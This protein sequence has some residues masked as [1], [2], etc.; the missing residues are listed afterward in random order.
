MLLSSDLYWDFRSVLPHLT[1]QA[2][3]LCTENICNTRLVEHLCILVRCCPSFFSG[4]LRIWQFD[5]TTLGKVS[6]AT[7]ASLW[8]M[9]DPSFTCTQSYCYELRRFRLLYLLYIRRW[10]VSTLTVAHLDLL[11]SIVVTSLPRG[12]VPVIG[13]RKLLRWMTDSSTLQGLWTMIDNYHAG[14]AFCLLWILRTCDSHFVVT[15]IVCN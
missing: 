4:R 11:F 5:R 12:I 10:T 3:F 13:K 9:L 2:V 8:V 15:L 6:L 14:F 7:Y 1:C